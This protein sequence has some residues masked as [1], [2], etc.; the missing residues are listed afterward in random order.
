MSDKEKDTE[1]STFGINACSPE[2]Q[3][4]L[5]GWI[6]TFFEKENNELDCCCEKCKSTRKIEDLLGMSITDLTN[7]AQGVK[8]FDEDLLKLIIKHWPK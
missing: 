5:Q 1:D 6:R 7:E 2:G 4:I 8:T 3:K